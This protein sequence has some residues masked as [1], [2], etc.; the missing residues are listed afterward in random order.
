MPTWEESYEGVTLGDRRRNK[1]LI[2]TAQQIEQITEKKG[3][4]ATLRGH[5]E[6]KAVSRL[7]RTNTVT[8][9]TITEGFIRHTCGSIDASHVLVVEDTSEF[10]FAWR[11]KAISGLGPTG[12]GED[13]GFFIHPAIVVEPEENSVIGLAAIE[14]HV[15]EYG[16]RTTENKAHKKKDIEEKESYRWITAARDG[17]RQLAPKVKKTIVADREADIYDLFLMHHEG[18][19]GE[20]C[21][22]LIRAS[23]NRKISDG[24]EYLFDE[25]ASWEPRH[26]FVLNVEGTKKRAKRSATCDVRYGQITIEVPKTQRGKSGV[27][28]IPDI[29][30]VDVSEDNSPSEENPIHWTLL[31]TWKVTTPEEALEKIAWY[32]CRWHIEEVFRI[33]KSGYQTESARFDDAHQLINWCALRLVM[34]VK[35]MYIRTRRNDET[36]ESARDIYSEIEIRILKAC[37]NELISPRSTIYRPPAETIAWASLLVA[38][39]GGYQALPS[40]KPFGQVTLWR[41][42]ARLEGAVIGYAAAMRDVGRS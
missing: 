30:V 37:E 15:R 23:Y 1:R 17:C 22:L 12:N 27:K 7:M 9:H 5:A 2:E 28:A 25:I 24:K 11:K 6:L 18:K 3:V 41:G 32:R 42:L 21:E 40:A 39:M 13:Q 36:P 34:A 31:T 26:R 33:L 38:I 19:L 29:F 8:P 16:V 4:S 10:N 35:L 14:V 20:N